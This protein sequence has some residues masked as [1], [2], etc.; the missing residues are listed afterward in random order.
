MSS[1]TEGTFKNK[2]GPLFLNSHSSKWHAEVLLV[3]TSE[4]QKPFYVAVLNRTL[5]WK[6]RKAF[7]HSK[8]VT[9]R[10]GPMEEYQVTSFQTGEAGEQAAD[11][12]RPTMQMSFNCDCPWGG[13]WGQRGE[14][15]SS[16]VFLAPSQQKTTWVSE[17]EKQICILIL[18]VAL[19]SW[20]TLDIN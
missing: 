3:V 15:N 12:W 1:R 7:S 8:I 20:V 6:W 4:A 14:S 11:V 18:A 17:L 19:I 10:V 5:V 13:A 2:S 9:R 16:L